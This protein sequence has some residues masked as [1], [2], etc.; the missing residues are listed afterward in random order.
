MP[1]ADVA[2]EPPSAV[3]TRCC[4]TGATMSPLS[5]P[6]TQP[7][8]GTGSLWTDSKPAAVSWTIAHSAAR[9]SASVAARR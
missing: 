7:V 1:L 6:R 9:A 2:T 5:A 3:S 8:I 4:A